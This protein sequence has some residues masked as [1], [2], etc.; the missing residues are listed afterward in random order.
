MDAAHLHLSELTPPAPVGYA[1]FL[2]GPLVVGALVYRL[3]LAY[4]RRAGTIAANDGVRRSTLTS[5]REFLSVLLYYL[6]YR[7]RGW[8]LIPTILAFPAGY[9]A[10]APIVPI[11]AGKSGFSDAYSGF[12]QAAAA[13]TAGLLIAVAVQVRTPDRKARFAT[14]EA[15]VLALLWAAV[16]EVA[17]LG[18]LSPSLPTDLHRP[19]FRLMVSGAASGLVALVFGAGLT[20]SG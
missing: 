7:R 2:T 20:D 4:Y 11:A 5:V 15:D 9:L 13:M 19:A 16:A 8:I 17:V 18:M 6:R 1:I 12:L 14:R 3:I 10:A